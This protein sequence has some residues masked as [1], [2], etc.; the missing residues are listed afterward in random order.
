MES[1]ELW[2]DLCEIQLSHVV[3]GLEMEDFEE[4]RIL[5]NL[6]FVVTTDSPEIIIV[7]VLGEKKDLAGD[8]FCGG[9]CVE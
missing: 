5:E 4:M 7:K 8:Y 6:G 9:K 2:K 3:F 1:A